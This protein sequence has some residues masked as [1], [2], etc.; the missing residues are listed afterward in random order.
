MTQRCWYNVCHNQLLV[1]RSN[2]RLKLLFTIKRYIHITEILGYVTHTCKCL[3]CAQKLQWRH[4][5]VIANNQQLYSNLNSSG[6]TAKTGT[7]IFITGPLRECVIEVQGDRWILFK[8]CRKRRHVMPSLYDKTYK[9]VHTSATL[10][11]PP[12]E[13]IQLTKIYVIIWQLYA[14]MS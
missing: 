6:M 12:Q 1:Q 5:S 7:Y 2:L 3:K 8:Y 13:F 14:I 9:D 11:N 4:M 10:P